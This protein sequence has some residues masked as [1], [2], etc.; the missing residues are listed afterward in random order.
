MNASLLAVGAGLLALSLYVQ[1]SDF[2]KANPNIAFAGGA[3]SAFLTGL[4][5][6]AP[7]KE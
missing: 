6:K 2:G 7:G 4:G 3:V 5:V 1:T